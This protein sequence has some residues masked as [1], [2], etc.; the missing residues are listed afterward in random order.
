MLKK[1]ATEEGKDWDQLIPYL[2]FAYREVPQA[3]TGFS[4][5]ELLYGRQVRGPLDILQGSWEASKPSSEGVVSYI[6]TVQEKLEKLRDIV[7]MNVTDAQQKNVRL[8]CKKQ[9]VPAR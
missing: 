7:Q 1:A 6:M 3:S 4:P 8:S 9:G 2:L 5:F